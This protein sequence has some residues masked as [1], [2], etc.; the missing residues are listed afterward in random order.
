MSAVSLPEPVLPST[1]R[2][3]L[4]DKAEALE[5]LVQPPAS[6]DEHPDRELIE[7]QEGRKAWYRSIEDGVLDITNLLPAGTE[8]YETRKLFEFLTEL[9]RAI[10]ADP[11]ITDE[12][13]HVALACAKMLDVLA[14]IERALEHTALEDPQQAA[15]YLFKCLET[16]SAPELA[17]LLDVSTK[18][19][20]AWKRGGPIRMHPRRVQLVAQLCTYLRPATTPIG[21]LMWFRN[22]ADVLGGKTPLAL[23][24][25]GE[26]APGAWRQLVEFARGARGQLAS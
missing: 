7:R 22:P 1:V 19:V 8:D 3:A 20:G 10:E 26:P 9:R 14:R 4:L 23:L 24:R 15:K 5:A 12:T 11:G 18:T 21:I 2:E 25:S 6:R 17:E 16:L 13:G